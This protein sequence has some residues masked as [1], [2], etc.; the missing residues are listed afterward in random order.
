MIL[1]QVQGTVSQFHCSHTDEDSFMGTLNVMYDWGELRRWIRMTTAGIDALTGKWRPDDNKCGLELRYFETS[2]EQRC[3]AA[4]VR[5]HLIGPVY[6]WCN[7][8]FYAPAFLSFD[9]GKYIVWKLC[10]S[11][12]EIVWLTW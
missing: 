7:D 3:P 10:F 5:L 12:F 9:K 11:Y 1:T 4:S 8:L 2:C 6:F